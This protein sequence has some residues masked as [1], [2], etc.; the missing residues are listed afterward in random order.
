MWMMSWGTDPDET[1]PSDGRVPIWALDPMIR[2][3]VLQACLGPARLQI[4]LKKA[5]YDVYRLPPD[6]YPR[7]MLEATAQPGRLALITQRE[8]DRTYRAQL[9]V[10]EG[11]RSI[12]MWKSRWQAERGDANWH[13]EF[14][15]MVTHPLAREDA[16]R[17]KVRQAKVVKGRKRPML[18]S[19]RQGF[20]RPIGL[21]GRDRD[22]PGL[23]P[24]Q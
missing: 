3:A 2:E 14:W 4:L 24:D 12:R 8:L 5:G 15:A 1:K 22:G 17:N 9:M 18:M 11:I 20:V 10:A 6:S 23:R 13:G 16:I 21:H 19:D 7:V